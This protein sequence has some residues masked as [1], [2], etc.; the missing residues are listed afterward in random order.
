MYVY[1]GGGTVCGSRAVAQHAMVMGPGDS[2]E[3][4]AGDGGMK[5]LLIAGR[6][7]NEPI[8]QHGPFVMNTQVRGECVYFASFHRLCPY[9]PT[10]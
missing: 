7:I 5:F 9:M 6:P 10:L 2:V 1:A 4:V 8:V 3:A